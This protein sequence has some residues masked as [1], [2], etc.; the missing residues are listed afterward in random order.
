M[1]DEELI[2][3]LRDDSGNWLTDAAADRIE[4]LVKER[5]DL[6]H[7]LERIKDSETQQ[8][9]RAER[10]EAAMRKAI[11]RDAA[12][13][14]AKAAGWDGELFVRGIAALPAVTQ[15]APDAAATREAALEE[16]LH[17]IGSL[18]TPKSEDIM[19]GH[20]EA[21]RAVEALLALITEKPH[22]RA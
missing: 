14:V 20:E 1:T 21:Y 5:D 15:P 18:P 6:I 12:L 11:D 9:N 10:L 2:A 7:D 13:A 16:V 4:A 3:L 19:R 22:D 17:L 8:L